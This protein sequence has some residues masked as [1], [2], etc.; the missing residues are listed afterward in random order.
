MILA[1]IVTLPTA[2]V[3][4]NPVTEAVSSVSI[5]TVPTAD[6]PKT[7]LTLAVVESKATSVVVTIPTAPMP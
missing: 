2:D 3:P 1:E 4:A 6:A 7:P 5:V